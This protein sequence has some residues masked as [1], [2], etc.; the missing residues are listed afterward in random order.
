M[1][2]ICSKESLI[3]V[4]TIAESVISTKNSISILSNVLIESFGDKIKIS[5]SETTLNFYAE[6]S[7]EIIKEGSISVY[8]NR[9]YSIVRKLE[10]DEIEISSD[11]N[12]VVTI[13]PKDKKTSKYDL[14]GIDANKFPP[15]NTSE[16]I[17]FFSIKQE[18]FTEMVKKTIFAIS[19]TES[20]RFVSG[21]LF[22]KIENSIR[23]VSTDGKRLAFVKKDIDT[24]T[25]NYNIIVP[26]KILN[27]VM[28]LCTGNGDLNIAL[29]NKNIFI[30]INNFCFISNLLEGNFPPYEKVIPK[31]QPKNFIVNRK[32]FF[33]SIDRISLI[34]D[35]ESHKIILSLADG[36]LRIF[37]EN[38]AFGSGEEIIPIEYSGEEFE[39]ALNYIF[40]TD[41]LNV[42]T[43][44][45]I[46]VEFKDSQNTITIREH[47]NDDYI[48]IMMPM[49]I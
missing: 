21:I 2:I 24:L 11:E 29:N 39:I 18:I 25:D 44:D 27:E 4:L 36:N 40:I 43:Q 28:K 19:N 8:C 15:I 20:R 42:L 47:G 41:V 26:P 7:G 16:G 33:N 5:A 6:I 30:K 48:Y 31:D 9:L 34:G 17:E 14:K 3:K 10:G 23:M 35:K 32:D 46:I 1:E 12:N 13:K 38:I 49:S 45:K 22:E 37:T